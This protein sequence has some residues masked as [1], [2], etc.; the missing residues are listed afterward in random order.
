ML[1]KF[2]VKLGQ[3]LRSINNTLHREKP[4]LPV[5]ETRLANDSG[6]SAFSNI[7]VASN[8]W[9]SLHEDLRKCTMVFTTNSKYIDSLLCNASNS[10]F[11][12][13]FFQSSDDEGSSRKR[14]PEGEEELP[15]KKKRALV[16]SDDEDEDEVEGDVEEAEEAEEAEE[17][18]EED[19][20]EDAD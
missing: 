14:K 19:A 16:V 7:H 12:Y 18:V 2:S 13:I 5:P 8:I 1:S 15:R 11:L 10:I 17:D 9:N 4:L 6:T 20:E 3:G